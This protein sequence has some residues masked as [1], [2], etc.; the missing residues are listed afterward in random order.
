MKEAAI[1]KLDPWESA[2]FVPYKAGSK[3][4]DKQVEAP[5]LVTF[6]AESD[7]HA[8]TVIHGDKPHDYKV[9]DL[10][11]F[12]FAAW[13]RDGAVLVDRWDIEDPPTM[14]Q[15]EDH[16][17]GW[18]NE[19]GRKIRLITF[20]SLAEL[21]H[22]SDFRKYAKDHTMFI[23]ESSMHVLT[24][25]LNIIDAFPYFNTNL[26]SVAGFVGLKKISLGNR[27]DGEPWITHMRQLKTEHPEVFWPY[28]ENDSVILL[29]AFTEFRKIMW[30]SF[31]I[32]VLRNPRLTPTISAIAIRIL[33]RDYLD[34]PI[35][36]TIIRAEPRAHRLKD[37]S[38]VSGKDSVKEVLDQNVF[39]QIRRYALRSAGGGGRSA[40]GCGFY[41]GP[42]TKLDSSGHYNVSS[43]QQPLP[44][45]KT[46]WLHLSGMD[47]LDEILKCEGYV[48][49][50]EP[51]E[52]S[53]HP[54]LAKNPSYAK[55]LLFTKSDDE[56]YTTIFELRLALKE[57]DLRFK[58]VE[59]YGFIPT[60]NEINNPL[61][62]LM[63]RFGKMKDDAAVEAVR[64]GTDKDEYL[65]YVLSK[66]LSNALIGKFIQ[67]VEN[68]RAAQEEFFEMGMVDYDFV[69][70]GRGKWSTPHKHVSESAFA[71]EWSALIL[72]RGR[73]ILGLSALL[74]K[75]P[76]TMH[77]DSVDFPTNLDL[78][79]VVVKRLYEEY[80]FT[81]K[82]KYRADG[83]WLMRSAVNIALHKRKNG[84][85]EVHMEKQKD[86]SEKPMMA[87]HAIH[88][89]RKPKDRA[90]LYLPV[91][92]A[93]NGGTWNPDLKV[94]E[95]RI[96]YPLS[97]RLH[98]GVHFGS[99]YHNESS[100]RLMWD[101]KRELPGDF[102]VKRD[103]FTRFEWT[104]P[105]ESVRASCMAEYI[106]DRKE[107]EAERGPIMRGR[108]KKTT[109]GDLDEIRG[110]L[111]DEL[112]GNEIADK[113][114]GR[115][116]RVTVQRLI[117]GITG[118]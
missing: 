98:G 57:T 106:H 32:E 29:K 23:H 82:M 99:S 110:Y 27:P 1:S 13:G 18:L 51:W 64:V 36:P 94:Y 3:R 61:K 7:S 114:A 44:N 46:V 40:F 10:L 115:L 116:S 90:Q 118:P 9:Q 25:S 60:E 4:P 47:V 104:R 107:V 109:T 11:C 66:L 85:W 103:L 39:I 108:P 35:Q 83:L 70:R 76:I 48:R 84:E 43:I 79:M 56:I 97:E 52:E 21:R 74:L 38:Y 24:E 8:E 81:F 93:I 62:R 59:A 117:K 100:V 28:A 49:L 15:L 12:T 31:A 50:V 67:A 78:E 19:P 87:N 26:D 33:R 91:C 102:D 88:T 17:R 2:V 89:G 55:R 95:E 30:D 71:P 73:G 58:D 5:L 111:T 68:D 105:Y 113:F 77:T 6:D 80:G 20:W 63:E 69:K 16:I 112:S 92:A 14:V 41:D 96:V 65:P 53:E 86:G 45:C 72:G 34:Y 22:I 75:Q 37:G 54:I 42:V 101:Y